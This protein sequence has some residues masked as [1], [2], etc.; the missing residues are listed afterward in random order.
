MGRSYSFKPGYYSSPPKIIRKYLCRYSSS[1]QHLGSDT[2]MLFTKLSTTVT[3]SPDRVENA[4]FPAI[5]AKWYE[6]HIIR[7]IQSLVE[8]LED[9]RPPKYDLDEEE[10]RYWYLTTSISLCEHAAANPA[11][12]LLTASAH[13]ESI[14]L[15]RKSSNETQEFL[16]QYYVFC[17]IGIMTC[18]YR[19]TISGLSRKSFSIEEN[20]IDTLHRYTCVYKGHIN[21]F[22]ASRSVRH[23]LKGFGELLPV[24]DRTGRAKPDH[25]RPLFAS[26]INAH[27]LISVMKINFAWTDILGAHLDFDERT[28]TLYLFRFPSFCVQNCYLYSEKSQSSI[29][30]A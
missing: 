7:S 19:P 5:R 16:Q 30:S 26:Q 24:L 13:L 9:V 12:T 25:P 11:F 14:G 6:E 27:V 4:G 18:L 17:M 20:D 29:L 23:A 2:E 15:F 22:E 8:F 1:K 21:E 3:L 28:R 10:K